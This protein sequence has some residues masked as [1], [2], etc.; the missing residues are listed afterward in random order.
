M[1]SSNLQQWMLA[2]MH[3]EAIMNLRTMAQSAKPV[4]IAASTS[5]NSATNNALGLCGILVGTT[6]NNMPCCCGELQPA[7][8]GTI[9]AKVWE[10]WE[11]TRS[12]MELAQ[13]ALLFWVQDP[14]LL[15]LDVHGE[16]AVLLQSC[17]LL[18]PQHWTHCLH[19]AMLRPGQLHDACWY[20]S[21]AAP[22]WVVTPLASGQLKMQE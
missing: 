1:G 17:A 5:S 16:S 20:S 3:Q 11:D 13:Q 8:L 10:D 7:D 6:H 12:N 22:S 15:V 21:D 9:G 14:E 19:P 18:A 2:T 4:H